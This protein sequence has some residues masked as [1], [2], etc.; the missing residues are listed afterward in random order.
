[1]ITKFPSDPNCPSQLLRKLLKHNNPK[2]VKAHMASFMLGSIKA[3]IDMEEMEI[4][5]K[6]AQ[7]IED[8]VWKNYYMLKNAYGVIEGIYGGLVQEVLGG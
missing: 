3:I 2:T 5:Q 1:M 4:E 8:A 7:D 6:P